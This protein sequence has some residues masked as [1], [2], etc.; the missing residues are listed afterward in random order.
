MLSNLLPHLA[1]VVDEVCFIK[2][3]YTTQFNHGPAQI[4]Q[5]TGHQIPGRPSFGAWLSY[6]IGTE[7]KD[8]PAFVAL[9]SGGGNPD[10]GSVCWSSGFL[11]TIHQGVPFQRKGDAVNFVS[12]PAGMES[13]TRRR[14]LSLIEKLNREHLEQVQDPEIFTRISAYEM[15][16]K[17]QTSVPGL[18]DVASE[19][20]SIHEMYGTTPGEP[21]FANNCLLARRLVERG[22]RFVQLCHRAWDMHGVAYN[23]DVIT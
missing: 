20:A 4:F 22:V 15:A 21:S 1:E 23:N 9:L 3:M 7:G 16:Y 17:M 11:P 5:M 13:E 10:G 18:M 12:N 2:S 6:G 14:S 19:P 8:L